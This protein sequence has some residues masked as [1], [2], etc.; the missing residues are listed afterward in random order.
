MNISFS[1]I[2]K[3]LDEF[4]TSNG[5]NLLSNA[6]TE[7]G[8]GTLA[9]ATVLGCL[10]N[11]KNYNVCYVQPSMRPADGRYGENANRLYTHHQY[12]V[13][14]MQS[15]KFIDAQRLY[16]ESLKFIGVDLKNNDIRFI[17]DDWKNTSIG[18]F[19][20]GWE[21][22]YN[23]MEVTQFTYM[24][25]L[26]GTHLKTVPIEITYGLERLV[27]CIQEVENVM[28]VQYSKDSLYGDIFRAN[29]YEWSKY[30]LEDA[31]NKILLSH[32]K[33]YLSESKRFSNLKN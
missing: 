27:M 2:I 29:E 31:D 6:T 16:L 21:V 33:D 19:G 10:S 22:W 12:Q 13:I 30:A 14:L 18:A 23:G 1:H 24:Q 5:C 4:W 11:S 8:A 20:L 26:G 17:E 7:V 15:N 25:Q 32:F 3:K 28:D 9:P